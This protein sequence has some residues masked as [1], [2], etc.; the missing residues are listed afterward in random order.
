MKSFEEAAAEKGL[1]SHTGPVG[2]TVFT[3]PIYQEPKDEIFQMWQMGLRGAAAAAAAARPLSL[4]LQAAQLGRH[5]GPGG[6]EGGRRAPVLSPGGAWGAGRRRGSLGRSP[7]GSPEEP[8][9]RWR[10]R[11]RRRQRMWRPSPSSLGRRREWLPSALALH[12][13]GLG[14][15]GNE[16]AVLATGL[17][18]Y[19]QELF[20]HLDAPGTGALPRQDFQALCRVL[21]LP[22]GEQ[23]E[24]EEEEEGRGLCR[25]L[26]AELTF[27]QFHARLCGYFGAHQEKAE[28][29]PGGSLARMPLGPE[30]EHIQAQIRLR[31]PLRRRRR[32]HRREK[33]APRPGGQ[34]AAGPASSPCCPSRECYE[35]VVALEQAEDRI[36]RLEDENA[37]LRELVEDMRA[38][39]QS[40]DARALAL[41][42]GLWKIHSS[43]KKNGTCF[44][45]NRRELTN[46]QSQTSK[47]LQSVLKELELVRSSRDGQIEEAIKF[48]QQL[49]K[50]LRN[51]REAL[52]ALED[53]NR[54]LKREQAEMRKKVEEARYAVLNSLEKV[55]ELEA[56]AQKVPQLQTYIQQ[57]ESELQY[58]RSEV[59]KLQVPSQG[60]PEKKTNAAI[61]VLSVVQQNRSSPTGGAG[62]SENVEEQMFRSVEG[63]AA[64]DEEEEKWTGDQQCQLA[65]VKKL[66]ARLPCCSNRYDD[67]VMKKLGNIS[68]ECHENSIVELVKQLSVL[69]EQLEIKGQEV[70]TLETNM[71]KNISKRALGKILL[72]TLESC[73]DPQH[74]KPHIAEILDTLC[75][76][77]TTCELIQNNPLEKTPGHQSLA[78]PL[79]I[80]C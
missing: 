41:Q 59:L 65:E 79:V 32:H 1:A 26:P 20:H 21:G 46:T 50:E 67:T 37:S 10:R 17:D 64:S 70:K 62:I 36:L 73:C 40:S 34:P 35:E 12:F 76:K 19:L 8:G 5:S 11:R 3:N 71:E 66:L 2:C 58:Y 72:S 53:C 27:R 49:E 44:I 14:A 68:K 29:G 63:Q 61:D 15:E 48:N 31:S 77:L 18:Q 6:R 24:G 23:E 43:H 60:S 55:K 38:A 57:L 54:T 7:G 25:G 13:G 74:G 56:K 75:H 78:N 22:D 39:L 16:V 45:G 42:V 47:C 4:G 51:S 69:T 80:S 33:E 28:G 30:T 52:V 9:C